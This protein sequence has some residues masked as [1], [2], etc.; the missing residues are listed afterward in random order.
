MGA[1]IGPLTMTTDRAQT[2]ISARKQCRSLMSAPLPQARAREIFA[3][4]VR[5]KGWTGEQQRSMAEFGAW[6]RERPAP[7]A[8]KPRYEK[9]LFDLEI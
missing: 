4:L 8:L 7:A 2:L 5:A 9:L 3:Q 1:I 6:L